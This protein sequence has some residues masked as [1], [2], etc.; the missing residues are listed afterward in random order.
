M[1]AHS[2]MMLVHQSKVRETSI[3]YYLTKDRDGSMP[4]SESAGGINSV[5]CAASVEHHRV[6][7]VTD[8]RI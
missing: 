1:R 7:Q 4:Q 8:V 2:R 5:P 3:S 6:T